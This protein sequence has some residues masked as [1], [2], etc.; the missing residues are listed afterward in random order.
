MRYYDPPIFEYNVQDPLAAY[1]AEAEA[2]ARRPSHGTWQRTVVRVNKDL[3]ARAHEFTEEEEEWIQRSAWEEE[4]YIL[5]KASKNFFRHWNS[6]SGLDGR[7]FRRR[8]RRGKGMKKGSQTE[9]EKAET[10]KAETKKA[11][12]KKAKKKK[13]KA[14]KPEVEKWKPRSLR[15]RN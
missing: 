1:E 2:G 8:P 11:E 3:G 10:K 6:G 9:T 4:E 5:S 12:T 13:A 14:D 15:R 7:S